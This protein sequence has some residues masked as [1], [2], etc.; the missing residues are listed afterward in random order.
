MKSFCIIFIIIIILHDGNCFIEAKVSDY[1]FGTF[2]YLRFFLLIF[3]TQQN[4]WQDYIKQGLQSFFPYV[5]FGDFYKYISDTEDHTEKVDL[6][7]VYDKPALKIV[8]PFLVQPI[9]RKNHEGKKGISGSIQRSMKKV[10]TRKPTKPSKKKTTTKAKKTKKTTKHVKHE[11]KIK[12][13]VMMTSL[14]PS[15]AK[16]TH[17]PV[18][19]TKS[20][21][22]MNTKIP[23][24]KPT[25][26]PITKPTTKPHKSTRITK[27]LISTT[28]NYRS[29]KPSNNSKSTKKHL[30]TKKPTS[31]ITKPTPSKISK[32]T[33]PILLTKSLQ[34]TNS[35]KTTRTLKSTR[36]ITPIKKL[37]SSPHINRLDVKQAAPA[38][39]TATEPDYDPRND[40]EYIV[41]DTSFNPVMSL[42]KISGNQKGNE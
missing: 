10:S 13:K 4:P 28:K 38:P 15:N 34:S 16:K 27:K 33:K 8:H 42:S 19:T 29:T 14:T 39:E 18:K 31:K 40:Y 2:K 6:V 30:F 5:K 20:G 22:T 9:L 26:K 7:V 1:N 17:H 35:K 37:V 24:T 11:S 36:K 25:T 41:D 32:S 3:F 12:Q 23:A 21:I